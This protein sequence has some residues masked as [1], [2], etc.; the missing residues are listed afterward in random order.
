M[1]WI[2]L[3]FNYGPSALLV[4]FVFIGETRARSAVLNPAINRKVSIP[5]Y[6]ANWCVIFSLLGFSLNVFYRTNFRS[7]YTIKGGIRNLQGVEALVSASPYLYLHKQYGPA[8]HFDYDLRVISSQQLAD[9]ERIPFTLQLGEAESEKVRDYELT[10]QS[11]YY[12]DIVDIRYDR[13]K[14]KLFLADGTK[15]LEIQPAHVE[16]MRA[17]FDEAP[18]GPSLGV[19]K[20]QAQAA[21]TQVPIQDRL[22]SGDPLIRRQARMDLSQQKGQQW[23]YIDKSLSNPYS[24]YRVKLGVLTALGTNSCADLPKLS[25]QALQTVAAASG[26]TDMALRE[27]ARRC[28]VTQASPEVEAALDAA[29]HTKLAPSEDAAELAKTQ[30]EVLYTLGIKAKDRYGSRQAADKNEFAA[31]V[32]DFQKAWGLRTAARPTDQVT[33][34]K[35]LFGWGLALHDRS[36][37]ERGPSKQRSAA[38]VKAARGK[39]AEFLAAVRTSPN[40]QAYAYPQHLRQAQ[41]YLASP[42]PRSLQIN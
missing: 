2:K 34:A 15:D 30:L 22:E 18:R 36:W 39:F 9:G 42:E 37:I 11:G 13:Q 4:F 3:L 29:A 14:D 27:V 7:E 33:F 23:Q 35:A 32:K 21:P 24:S 40:P 1:D 6:V 5:I 8:G 25:A 38:Y 26:E 12:K 16:A 10:V 17:S 41:A 20:V 31:A 28:L 19:W